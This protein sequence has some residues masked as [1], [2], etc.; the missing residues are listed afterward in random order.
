M[1]ATS[2]LLDETR[3]EAAPQ[4]LA[5]QYSSRKPPLVSPSQSGSS[6]IFHNTAIHF[7]EL[8]DSPE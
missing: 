1:F 5:K 4:N 6:D 2:H 3:L 7:P 8:K